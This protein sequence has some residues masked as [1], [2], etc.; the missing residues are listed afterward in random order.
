VPIFPA[1]IG[2]PF[3]PILCKASHIALTTAAGFGGQGSANNSNNSTRTRSDAPCA[4]AGTRRDRSLVCANQSLAVL[5][6]RT[7]Q[8]HHLVRLLLRVT[9]SS[10]IGGRGTAGPPSREGRS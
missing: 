1:D 3:V 10:V 8:Q 7:Q 5:A 9:T 2:F 4:S 6:A